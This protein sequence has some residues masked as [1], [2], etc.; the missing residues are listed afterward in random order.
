M[1]Y[2]GVGVGLTRR[3]RSSS[4]T[5]AQARLPLNAREIWIGDSLFANGPMRSVRQFHGVLANG[6]TRPTV[7]ANFGV[8]GQRMD[9]ILADMPQAVAQ[10]P[11]SAHLIGGTNDISQNRTLAQMQA[12]HQGIVDILKNAGCQYIFRHTIPRSTSISGANETKRQDF[13]NWLRS[14]TDVILIDHE[15]PF[16]PAT[17]DS[18]DGTHPSGIGA[19]EMAQTTLA[20]T[21]QYLPTGTTLYADTTDATAQGN[22]EPDWNFVGT[23]GTRSGTTAPTG[24]VATGWTLTNNTSCAV[25]ASKLTNGSFNIQRFD[26]TGT[27]STSNTVKLTNTISFAPSLTP[28]EWLDA[29]IAVDVVNTDGVSAPVGCR[30]L[31]VQVGSLGNW[32]TAN[33]DA[34]AGNLPARLTG[35]IRTEPVSLNTTSASVTFEVTVQVPAGAVNIRVDVSRLK[36]TKTET[37]AYASPLPV[38]RNKT[39]PRVT[40]TATVG[41]TL[42][43]EPQTWAGGAI[44]YTYQWQRGTVNI[45]GAT[46]RTYVIQAADQGNTLRCLITGTNSFGNSVYTTASTT[47]V[48]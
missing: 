4:G 25:A 7:G 19:L 30:S 18:Y 29:A 37:Q 41:S 26:I 9:E 13:N 24:Q 12:D 23:T 27:A 47:T 40:G 43:A 8:G 6:N 10:A 48:P 21:A 34:S 17:S 28:G 16:D 5:P 20:V 35:V 39:L 45:S 31:L 1:P 38:L 44:T 46:A 11:L 33:A 32:G 15:T 2:A 3:R 42:T 14:R 22:L 36:I